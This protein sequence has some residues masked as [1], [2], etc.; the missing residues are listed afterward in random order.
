ML[1]EAQIA[2]PSNPKA[3]QYKYRIKV[4]NKK[5]FMWLNL[6]GV[7]RKFKTPTEL[8]QQLIESLGE[9]VPTESAIDGFSVGYL[10][11]R[12]QAKQ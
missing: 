9:H 5:D 2:T 11:K 10:K 8:K 4:I 3:V 1:D 6:H 12:S 7:T